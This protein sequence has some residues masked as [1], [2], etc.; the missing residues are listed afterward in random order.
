MVEYD[1]DEVFRAFAEEGEQGVEDLITNKEPDK[2]DAELDLLIEQLT[3]KAFSNP[4]I[5]N[6]YIEN[7]YEIRSKILTAKNKYRKGSIPTIDAGKPEDIKLELIK[8]F[9]RINYL[10]IYIEKFMSEKMEIDID[11][12][13][14]YNRKE[15]KDILGTD[16]RKILDRI[17]KYF[18]SNR[19]GKTVTYNQ[20]F[21]SKSVNMIDVKVND[22]KRDELKDNS[23]KFLQDLSSEK[24]GKPIFNSIK[25]KIF[26]I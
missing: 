11:K 5:L 21:N 26:M 25:L 13:S 3:E 20:L 19:T 14:P 18:I 6:R 17:L 23:D 22:G 4:D 8:F 1:D 16:A 9:A 7:T 24:G 12:Y 2:S 10:D 15:I